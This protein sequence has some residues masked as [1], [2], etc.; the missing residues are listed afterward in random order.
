MIVWA[1]E[2]LNLLIFN[3]FEFTIAVLEILL[4]Y[5]NELDKNWKYLLNE[6]IFEIG[7]QIF[8]KNKINKI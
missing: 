8:L 4:V 7:A 2:T 3:V 6:K 1:V 5:V